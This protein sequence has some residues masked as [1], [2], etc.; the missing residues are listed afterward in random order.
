MTSRQDNPDKHNPVAK[1][2]SRVAGDEIGEAA[3]GISGV[4]V[5]AA[6][7]S[8]GGPIGTLIGGIAGAVGGWWAGHSVA[9]A[10]QQYTVGD[11]AV[12]RNHYDNSP[13]RLGDRD[14]DSVSPAYRLGHLAAHNPDYRG[15]PF[16]D[17]EDELR[18]GWNGGARQSYG[19]W[20]SVRGYVN[21]A[22]DRS[23]SGIDQQRRREEA[24]NAAEEADKRLEESGDMNIF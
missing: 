13:N 12:Y 17:I 14:Y 19:E 8:V 1:D 24:N 3:G 5:G 6:I 20:D 9:E 10:A 15:R 21:D 18:R 16:N 2:P 7:G 11:D 23:A 4:V 22:Y